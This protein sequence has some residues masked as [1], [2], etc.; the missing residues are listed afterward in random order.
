MLA[1]PRSYITLHTYT[2]PPPKYSFTVVLINFSPR[3]HLLYCFTF[4]CFVWSSIDCYLVYF[5]LFRFIS[6]LVPASHSVLPSCF[7]LIFHHVISR[8]CLYISLFCTA[9]V[10]NDFVFCSVFF[11]ELAY[12]SHYFSQYCLLMRLFPVLFSF[13][14]LLS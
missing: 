10:A 5:M 7:L 14:S 13:T 12:V 1:L 3:R 11:H 8:R 2:L 9:L 6:C 4:V